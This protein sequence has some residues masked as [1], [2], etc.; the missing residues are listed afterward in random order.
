MRVWSAAIFAVVGWRWTASIAGPADRFGTLF[1]DVSAVHDG[2]GLVVVRGQPGPRAQVG[3]VGEA[4]HVADLSDE[5]RCQ[6]RV[7][8]PGTCWMA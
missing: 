7:P 8:M 6:R 3:G 2:V 5:H 4:V 1:G